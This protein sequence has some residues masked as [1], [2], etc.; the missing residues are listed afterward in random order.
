MAKF[1]LPVNW[2]D[3]YFEKIDFT[4]VS[5]LYGKLR[6]DFTGGGK[7][8]MAQAEPSKRM[9]AEYIKRAHVMGIKFNYLLNTTC[10]GNLEFTRKGY[11]RI[12]KLLDWL[13]EIGVYT[14]TLSMPF[15]VEVLKKHYPS[16]KVKISTQAGVNSLEKVRIWEEIGADA[17]TLSHVEMNRDFKEIKRITS[18]SKSEM[19][20]IANMICK[21]GCPYITLH[22]NFNAHAS[23]SWAK[24]NRYNLDYYFMACLAR[25][26]SNPIHVIKASWIR[27]ED[28]KLYEE[29]GIHTFKLAE[30]GLR[31]DALAAILKSYVAGKHTGNFIDLLPTMS[32]YVFMEKKVFIK[33]VKELFRLD[34]VNLFKMFGA[35]KTMKELQRSET[36]NEALDLYI[37]NS[38]LDGA[39]NV[40]MEKDCVNR[41][42]DGCGYCETLVNNSARITATPAQYEKDMKN[43]SSL[44]QDI[45]SGE[46]FN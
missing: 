33:T 20:L 44:V 10:I 41:S 16:I 43:L 13:G 9:V 2:Q 22:G 5:E 45:V 21:R 25:N 3:D 7:S 46:F 24:T 14:V 19:Q 30:R 36:Y 34:Y 6:E 29:L 23:H 32:K 38:A 1:T 8:S 27:P 4:G 42:C 35:V 17:F 31:S 40:F 39:I 11:H 26:F 28:I 18:N 12:R 37:E 15:L